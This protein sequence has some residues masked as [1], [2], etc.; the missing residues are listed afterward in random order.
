[1][2]RTAAVLPRRQPRQA[3]SRQTVERLL[4]AADRLLSQHGL[5]AFNTNAVAAAAGLDIAS[6]YQYFPSKEAIIYS[7]LEQRC[8]GLQA[9]C[10]LWRLDADQMPLPVLLEQV[11]AAL[12]PAEV[13]GWSLNSLQPMIDRVPELKE[14]TEALQQDLA[15]FWA[16]VLQQRGSLLPRPQLIEYC[17]LFQTLLSSG[18][19]FA[20]ARPDEHRELLNEWLRDVG[21]NMLRSCLPGGAGI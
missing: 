14:L 19:G 9:R 11:S 17:R 7:L 1:M 6:L 10:E 16:D 13:D 5:L 18:H 4:E 3:R 21:L 20:A 15:A 8:L 12:Y 2:V